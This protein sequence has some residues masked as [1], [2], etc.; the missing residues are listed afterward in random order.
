MTTYNRQSVTFTDKTNS[1][2]GNGYFPKNG[3]KKNHEL[4]TS[5]LGIEY[6]VNNDNGFCYIAL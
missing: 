3:M 1:I 4:K 6:V 2:L 5:I